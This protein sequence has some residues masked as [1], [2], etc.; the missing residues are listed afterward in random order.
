MTASAVLKTRRLRDK[1]RLLEMIRAGNAPFQKLVIQKS[2]RLSRR[3]GVEAM[4]E[5]REI[6]KAGIEIWFYGKRERFTYGD[7]KSNISNFTEAEFN[8]EFRR[9]SAPS[10]PSTRFISIGRTSSRRC[11]PKSRAGESSSPPPS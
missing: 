8:A 3:D 7:F 10:R 6:A 4:V 11:R 1:Q 9:V 2:D 5:L